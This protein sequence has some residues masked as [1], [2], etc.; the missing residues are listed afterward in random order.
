MDSAN[1]VQSDPDSRLRH[2]RKSSRGTLLKRCLFALIPA[3]TLL[4]LAELA[5]RAFVS[6]ATIARRFEQIEQI[7]V[8][9]GSERGESIF[10]TDPNCFWRLKPGVVLPAER[11][12]AWGGVMSNSQRL[13]SREIPPG[14][15]NRV[16][17]VICIGDSTTFGF[18][19]DFADA[20]PN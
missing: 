2:A 15:S 14:S 18:G 16:R 12:T 6:E 10:E 19:V 8:Y 5:A 3:L 13:R 11:G 20:W 1:S 9:L 4:G 17:R 7:I